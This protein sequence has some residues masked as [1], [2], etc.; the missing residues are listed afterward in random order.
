MARRSEIK[1]YLRIIMVWILLP[2]RSTATQI[3]RIV[4]ATWLV[5]VFLGLII[6]IPYILGT[7]YAESASAL[8]DPVVW[9]LFGLIASAIPATFGLAYARHREH[10]EEIE[11]WTQDLL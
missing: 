7:E 5:V 1:L 10:V 9:L 3:I 4:S 8:Q 2:H 6:G 11:E